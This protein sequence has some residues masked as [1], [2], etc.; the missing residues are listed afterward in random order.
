MMSP[1]LAGE[2]EGHMVCLKSHHRP[3]TGHILTLGKFYPQSVCDHLLAHTVAKEL[4]SFLFCSFSF[5]FIFSKEPRISL[6][7][8]GGVPHS[9]IS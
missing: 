5:S 7:P 6:R 8:A 3:E 2:E 4:Y 1:P 9:P